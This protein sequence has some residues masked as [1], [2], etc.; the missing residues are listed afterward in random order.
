MRLLA[1]LVV[2]AIALAAAARL[3]D[4]FHVGDWGAL[5]ALAVVFGLVNAVIR[6][7][8]KLFSLPLLFVTIGL[9]TFVINALML[10]L[11]VFVAQRF[12]LDVAL[13][14]FGSAFLAALVVSFVSMVL[15]WF[16]P[17]GDKN[18]DKDRD[19]RR[20]ERVE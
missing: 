4:G 3:I 20:I 19:T 1:R 16:I 7:V 12:E 18:R 2:N 6:P 17:D 11:A 15:S 10:Y 5:A 13:S 8:L 14:G 9:F